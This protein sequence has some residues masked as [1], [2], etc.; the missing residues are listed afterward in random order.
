M[1]KIINGIKVKVPKNDYKGVV[2][3]TCPKCGSFLINP[4]D[5]STFYNYN[6]CYKCKIDLDEILMLENKQDTLQRQELLDNL[7]YLLKIAK[8][9]LL[10]A[11]NNYNEENRVHD[12]INAKHE[13]ELLFQEKNN[14]IP[15]IKSKIL[16][17]Q[18][19]IDKLQ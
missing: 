11:E 9:E 16:D 8:S 5:P 10:D 7:L 12:I 18:S 17:L 4:L 2:E 15:E 14:L 13:V 19:Q 3:D 6:M 1:Y